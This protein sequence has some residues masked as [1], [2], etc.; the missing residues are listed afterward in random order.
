MNYFIYNGIK[1]SDLGVYIQNKNTFSS[2][3]YDASFVSIPGRNGDLISSNGRYPNS[4]ISYT[5]F[6]V[7][8]SIEELSDK[9]TLVKNWLYKE[10]DRYH[11]LIDSYDLKFKRI[12]LFNTKLDI[13]DEVNK[14]GTF[15]VVFS[16]KPQRYLVS[17]LEKETYT[18]EFVVNNPYSL[19]AKPYLKIYG[20]GDITLTI[21]SEGTNKI[22]IIK[23]VEEF[24]E[25][26]SELM[27]FYKDTELQ[28]SKV[29]GDD[30]PELFTGDNSIAWKG[31][32]TKVEIIK[33]LVTL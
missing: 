30:F 11:D 10:P 23:N 19:N 8:K 16:C 9:V 3:K 21:S 20:S 5:C 27:N 28:N 6:I 29:T 14:I 15:T 13:S 26:D 33:R 32:V 24:I 4:S 2:P 17:T 12:A 31:E 25:C 18:E 7:A 22:W 1:S